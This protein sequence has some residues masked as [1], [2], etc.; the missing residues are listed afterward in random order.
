[1][2]RIIAILF[3]IVFMGV[4]ALGCGNITGSEFI[5]KWVNNDRASETVE[6]KRNEQSFIVT[7]SAPIVIGKIV[8]NGEKKTTEYPAVLKD[9]ILT[10]NKGSETITISYV[11]DGDYLLVGGHK[12]IKQ[13]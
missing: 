1:M 7:Q 9:T 2:R 5:G 8:N 11:K 10:V 12:F 13:Q 3:L 6:I 4:F